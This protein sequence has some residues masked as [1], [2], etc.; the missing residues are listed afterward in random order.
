[1][2]TVREELTRLGFDWN[3]GIII[4][5]KVINDNNKFRRY[6]KSAKGKVIS[7]FH[8]ILDT[9]YDSSL[10]GYDAPRIIAKD[11]HYIY[12]LCIYD[13]ATWFEKIA[14]N[15]EK[16]YINNLMPCAGLR[17]DKI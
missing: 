11:K 12:F 10:S 1:M 9:K 4:Y 13:G 15:I 14:I 7:S 5:Q 3:K 16:E 6:I 2:K 8:P 17:V